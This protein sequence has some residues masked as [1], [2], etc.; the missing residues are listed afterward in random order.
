M[1][2]TWKQE[3]NL[4]NDEQLGRIA[5]ADKDSWGYHYYTLEGRKGCCVYG[6]AFEFEKLRRGYYEIMEHIHAELINNL[7]LTPLEEYYYNAFR[8]DCG[9][10][11]PSKIYHPEIIE[12][13]QTEAKRILEE[14]KQRISEQILSKEIVTA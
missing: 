4:L 8:S 1:T 6:H 5:F 10:V 12:E 9:I 2:I 14:R 7:I 13:I 11:D 3:L